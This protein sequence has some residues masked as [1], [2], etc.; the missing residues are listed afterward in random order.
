MKFVPKTVAV[1][2][3]FS[4]CLS[5]DFTCSHDYTTSNEQTRTGTGTRQA[6]E[7]KE[8]GQTDASLEWCINLH[9]DR[10]ALASWP[11]ICE[12]ESMLITGKLIVS[13]GTAH[14]KIL[15]LRPRLFANAKSE[16]EGKGLVER[17]ERVDSYKRGGT[18]EEQRRAHES[19]V[20]NGPCHRAA[21]VMPD[22]NARERGKDS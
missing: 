14:S 15:L 21:Y 16:R 17:L 12:T 2:K 8:K 18:K 11:R 10:S 9:N 6:K 19:R 1:K 7:R 3:R 4:R 20:F 13:E 5:D 22:I